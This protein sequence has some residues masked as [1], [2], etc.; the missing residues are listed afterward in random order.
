MTRLDCEWRTVAFPIAFVLLLVS[1]AGAE[2]S[3]VANHEQIQR[4]SAAGQ[5]A[6]AWI[7]STRRVPVSC[8][9]DVGPER[10]SYRVSGSACAEWEQADAKSFF[11]NTDASEPVIVFIH[12]NRTDSL[13]AVRE[14]WPV[15]QRLLSESAGQ[16]FRFVIWSWPAE[17]IRG[18]PRKD[19][20]VKA[21]R[22]D[23]QS[24]YLAAWLD[25]LPTQ[26]PVAL[27]GY[28][29][30]ARVIGGALH[31]SEG[32]TLLGRAH[33]SAMPDQTRRPMR[34]ML[35]A[36]AL[37]CEWLL[38]GSRNGLAGQAVEQMLI[39]RN[40]CD[41]V[42]RF[43]PRMRRCDSSN[44]LGFA[45]PASPGRLVESGLSLETVPVECQ[46][47][48]DH[49]W[50]NYLRSHTLRSRLAWYAFLPQAPSSAN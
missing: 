13:A 11:G 37:D 20:L 23:T 46:V 29:F 47:G 43:Y 44:A 34:V 6:E 25:R 45:G 2:P 19:A 27:I 16:S 14:G 35:V 3:R 10:F 24:F 36:A 26:T 38:P 8:P 33:V 17:R 22:S 28:S 1:A 48:S 30:G 40:T 7:V 12:G 49:D 31:L 42:L 50:L 32:G 4:T 5:T 15:Y 18:G 39:T 41:R 9:T 21:A